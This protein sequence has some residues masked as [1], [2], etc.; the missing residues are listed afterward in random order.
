MIYQFAA[1]WQTRQVHALPRLKVASISS[2][3]RDKIV[4]QQNTVYLVFVDARRSDKGNLVPQIGNDRCLWH[5]GGA[6]RVDVN[7]FIPGSAKSEVID[8]GSRIDAADLHVQIDRSVQPRGVRQLR[9]LIQR[10]A[11]D[12]F[13]YVANR[14]I[15]KSY[16]S[17][18]Y[19]DLVL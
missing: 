7:Q 3:N 12:F 16:H 13:S 19:G 15:K 6:R 11:R 4:F 2:Q 17:H 8:E 5:P 1:S 10:Q 9:P 14:W 18:C